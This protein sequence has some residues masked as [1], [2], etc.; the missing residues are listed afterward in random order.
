MSTR[1]NKG[2][3]PAKFSECLTGEET[4]TLIEKNDTTE[5]KEHLQCDGKINVSCHIAHDYI[6]LWKAAIVDYF[7]EDNTSVLKNG[8]VYKN[9]I[10]C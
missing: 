9:Y 8:C 2:K 10:R 5:P 1:G 7:G 4:D 6:N 3:P